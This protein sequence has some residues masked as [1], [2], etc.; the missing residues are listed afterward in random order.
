[1]DYIEPLRGS[2]GGVE[3][4]VAPLR[5]LP[6]ATIFNASGVWGGGGMEIGQ[7]FRRQWEAS[8]SYR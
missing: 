4:R 7:S 6:G 2:I 5:G 1:V 3:P 8:W